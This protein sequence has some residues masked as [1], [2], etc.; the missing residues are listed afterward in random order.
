MLDLFFMF[1]KGTMEAV[2]DSAGTSQVN[3]LVGHPL[4]YLC[5]YRGS[6]L[7]G[8]C[9]S[10]A[11][12]KMSGR[13]MLNTSQYDPSKEQHSEPSLHHWLHLSIAGDKKHK[14]PWVTNHAQRLIKKC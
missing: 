11:I 5:V 6:P 13:K 3:R 8:T 14:K 9:K 7:D 4:C 10:Y 2:V 12:C 1:G